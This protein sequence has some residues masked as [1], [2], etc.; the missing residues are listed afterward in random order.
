M[1][2]GLVSKKSREWNSVGLSSTGAFGRVDLPEDLESLFSFKEE[3]LPKGRGTGLEGGLD[4]TPAGELRERLVGVVFTVEGEVVLLGEGVVMSFE[5]FAFFTFTATFFATVFTLTSFLKVPGEE[6]VSGF[7]LTRGE[8]FLTTVVLLEVG[9]GDKGELLE[10]V[11]EIE[12]V[13]DVV[14]VLEVKGE[15]LEVLKGDDFKWEVFFEVLAVTEVET[16][17]FLGSSNLTEVLGLMEWV[18]KLTVEEVDELNEGWFEMTLGG[19]GLFGFLRA[20]LLL[21]RRLD[22]EGLNEEVLFFI[23]VPDWDN[24]DCDLLGATAFGTGY[25]GCVI[26]GNGSFQHDSLSKTSSSSSSSKPRKKNN[27]LNKIK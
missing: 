21:V 4:E 10:V 16:E 12:G 2:L 24:A 17:L 13:L 6:G 5:E 26:T 18:V 27:K 20:E 25:V 19:S 1:F 8:T 9:L 22:L 15:V 11:E 3:G 14:K 23:I 7:I